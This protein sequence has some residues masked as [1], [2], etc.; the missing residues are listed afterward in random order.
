MVCGGGGMKRW[1]KSS[2]EPRTDYIALP[3]KIVYW[4]QLNLN[5]LN[6]S[7]I[8]GIPVTSAVTYTNLNNIP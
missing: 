1:Y 8:K 2:Q 4:K 6:D 7:S 5:D 3:N